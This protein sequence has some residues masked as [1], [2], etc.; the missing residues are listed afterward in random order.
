MESKAK[1]EQ[2]TLSASDPRDP[3][4]EN[5]IMIAVQLPVAQAR[6]DGGGGIGGAA[7]CAIRTRSVGPGH[8]QQQAKKRTDKYARERVCECVWAGHRTT[9]IGRLQS[10]DLE[11][12]GHAQDLLVLVG[13][14]NHLPTPTTTA[15]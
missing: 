15:A 7:S 10:S 13:P 12:P 1:R 8:T 3:S 11:V 5:C 9:R 2:Y 14:P 6:V 4:E